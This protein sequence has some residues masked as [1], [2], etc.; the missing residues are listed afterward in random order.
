MRQVLVISLTNEASAMEVVLE[1]LQSVSEREELLHAY[2]A[3]GTVALSL[4]TIEYQVTSWCLLDLS[5][6]LDVFQTA[7]ISVA[8]AVARSRWK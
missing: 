3:L 6:S 2:W 4:E 1:L 8:L 7:A 5:I